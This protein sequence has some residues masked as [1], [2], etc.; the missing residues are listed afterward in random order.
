MTTTLPN[1]WAHK[2]PRAARER[3]LMETT[4][5]K[6]ESLSLVIDIWPGLGQREHLRSTLVKNR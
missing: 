1:D 5:E 2:P 6:T 4:W 3:S